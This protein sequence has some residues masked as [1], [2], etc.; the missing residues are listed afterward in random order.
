LAW[1]L[2]HKYNLFEKFNLE[3]AKFKAWLFHIEGLY[4]DTPYHSKTHAAD[5]LQTVHFFLSTC[6][7]A[8]FLTEIQILA[9]ILAAVVHDV[10][11]D[12]FNNAFHQA[13][14]TDRAVSFND[15]SIQE[16]FHLSTMYLALHKED[17]GMNIFSTLNNNQVMEMRR[18]MISMVLGTDMTRHFNHFKEFKSALDLCG[19]DATCWESH[20]DVLMSQILHVADISNPAKPRDTAVAWAELV[21]QEFFAQGD[22]EKSLGLPISPMCNRE[23]TN[24]SA[25]QIGFIKYIVLPT[26]ELLAELLPEV[27]TTCLSI[28]KENLE[29]WEE[30]GV[31]EKRESLERRQ[32]GDSGE[33]SE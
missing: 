14:L 8:D 13:A 12:G 33:K 24:L 21:V 32:S 3:K 18:M 31:K 23:T 9:L 6:N 22:R 1:H 30:R 28:L 7:A 29:Y 27:E 19:K 2:L 11:H 15:Q 25:T 4:N 20:V 5:V 26:Y 17:S 10:G 16:N